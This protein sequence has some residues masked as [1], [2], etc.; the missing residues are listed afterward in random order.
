MTQVF[1]LQALNT[2]QVVAV[3]GGVI[4]SATAFVGFD[5]AP[6]AGTVTI[7][8]RQPGS[9]VWSPLVKATA[10]SVATG[11]FAARVDGDIAAFRITFAG[12]VG[13]SGPSLWL[14]A[15]DFPTGLF[16][17]L[18]AMTVQNYPEANVKKRFTIQYTSG[19][20]IS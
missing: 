1:K 8:Y 7:E 13:G 9:A 20:A 5:V 4:G 11:E 12:L 16:N 14:T 6:S 15:H 2:Q 10:A 18:S 17:G 3:P 19:V